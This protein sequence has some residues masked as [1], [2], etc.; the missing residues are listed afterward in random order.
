[1]TSIR[2]C[3]VFF[4]LCVP[5]LFVSCPQKYDVF[6]GRTTIHRNDLEELFELV[7]K[8]QAEDKAKERFIINKQG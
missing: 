7:E 8:Y 5:L 6:L 1:M 2:V 4:C 3:Q